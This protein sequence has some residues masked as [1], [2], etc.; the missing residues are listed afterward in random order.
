M[1]ANEH[2][3][4]QVNRPAFPLFPFVSFVF[5][6]GENFVGHTIDL[7]TPLPAF[8]SEN[9]GRARARDDSSAY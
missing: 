9:R 8:E 2:E 6:A 5:F 1:I 3:G 7:T 4:K